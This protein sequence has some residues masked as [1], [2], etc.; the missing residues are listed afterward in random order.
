MYG[1]SGRPYS[2]RHPS[3]LVP[4]GRKAKRMRDFW[5][6]VG[7]E[8]KPKSNEG[9]LGFVLLREGELLMRGAGR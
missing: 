9:L 6:T 3:F 8:G 2:V 1:I 7:V 5:K 4:M